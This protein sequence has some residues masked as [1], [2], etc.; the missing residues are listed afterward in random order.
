MNQVV[1]L[2]KSEQE[3]FLNILIEKMKFGSKHNWREKG[4]EQALKTFLKI[5]GFTIDASR[6]YPNRLGLACDIT[7]VK[8][9]AL[10]IEIKRFRSPEACV[11]VAGGPL[12]NWAGELKG[13]PRDFLIDVAKTVLVAR[14]Q[15]ENQGIA[16]AFI[17]VDVIDKYH[18]FERLNSIGSTIAS[19]FDLE[20]NVLDFKIFS[21]NNN[22]R[23]RLMALCLSSILKS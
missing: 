21:D 5:N 11:S 6:P 12:N 19:T 22:N 23:V 18:Q 17:A 7:A 2:L 15:E 4:F 14:H 1:S 13:F 16:I 20:S 10:F 3:A 8:D 9:V